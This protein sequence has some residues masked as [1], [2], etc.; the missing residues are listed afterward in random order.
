MVTVTV[1][2]T[3][4]FVVSALFEAIVTVVSVGLIPSTKTDAVEATLFKVRFITLSEA[5]FS[6]P[7]FS[8]NALTAI[9]SLSLS[10]SSTA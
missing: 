9:P 10:D 2:P 5:S 4:A 8:S 7:L 3:F 1:S 6:V